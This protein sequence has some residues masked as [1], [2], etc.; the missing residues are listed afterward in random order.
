M[1]LDSMREGLVMLKRGLT[2]EDK[3]LDKE[4][5]YTAKRLPNM[6]RAFNNDYIRFVDR[7]EADRRDLG[8]W[9]SEGSREMDSHFAEQRAIRKELYALY[10]MPSVQGVGNA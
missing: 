2:L 3:G 4:F 10:K 5:E 6:L 8:V 7:L 9:M 1:L